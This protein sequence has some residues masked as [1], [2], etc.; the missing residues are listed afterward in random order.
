MQKEI[1]PLQIRNLY[2]AILKLK[3]TEECERFFRDLCTLSE[4]KAMSERWEVAKQVNKNIPYRLI[5]EK[6]G[7]STATVTRVAHW[8]HYGMGGYALMLKRLSR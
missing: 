6:T 4:L 3:T 5:S 8:L 7:A 1:L 2:Q